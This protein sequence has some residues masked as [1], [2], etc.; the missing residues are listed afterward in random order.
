MR[1]G[2]RFP[3][4]ELRTRAR[5]RTPSANVLSSWSLN[6]HALS[7]GMAPGVRFAVERLPPLDA[8]QSRRR[9]AQGGG[10]SSRMIHGFFLY[11]VSVPIKYHD[12]RLNST[13]AARKYFAACGRRKF[14]PY[15]ENSGRTCDGICRWLHRRKMGPALFRILRSSGC[16]LVFRFS[17]SRL[18]SLKIPEKHPP[19]TQ[20]LRKTFS[21]AKLLQF[22]P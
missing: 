8:V 19:A 15:R 14:P 17:F 6:A 12:S 21:A 16:L 18:S 10:P 22:S 4:L 20:S 5:P 1:H 3:A 9:A 2:R 13:P 7:A 11:I